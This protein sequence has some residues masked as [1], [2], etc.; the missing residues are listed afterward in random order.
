MTIISERRWRISLFV[1]FSRL[2]RLDRKVSNSCCREVTML[3]KDSISLE[4]LMSAEG[5]DVNE[6]LNP[7]TETE[8]G[9]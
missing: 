4:S 5:E 7:P 6:E 8:V 2:F 9:R 3:R 1:V